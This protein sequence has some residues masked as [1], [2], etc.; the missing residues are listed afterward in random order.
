MTTAA[1]SA[2]L[3]AFPLASLAFGGCGEVSQFAGPS[4]V[5]CPPS[6]SARDAGA[7]TVAHDL[8]GGP[9]LFSPTAHGFGISVVLRAGD[10][11]MLQAR[12]RAAGTTDRCAWGDP[13]P[14]TVRAPDLAEWTIDGLA[15]ATTYEY[16]IDG[17]TPTGDGVLAAGHAV[18]Q[19]QPGQSFTFALVSDTHIGAD[20]TYD[21]QGDETILSAT[22]REIAA[23]RA[24][25]VV[26]LGDILDYH[27]YGFV[28]P[29]PTSAIARQAYVNYRTTL[30]TLVG[31]AFHF[32]VIGGWDAENG[33]DTADVIDRSRSQRLLYL[34]APGP[35]TNPEGGSPF[36]DYYAFTWGDALFVVLNVFT[37]TPTCHLLGG[38]TGVADDWTLGQTQLDWLR[39]TLANARSKWKFLLI[40]HPVGGN[41]GDD[42]DSAYGRG[43]GRAAH[44]G[45]Q[46]IVHE[47]MQ[48][49]GVQ[50]FFYGH[51]HVFTDML[52]DGI[53]YSLPGSAGAIWMFTAAETGYETFWPD[54]G[55]GRVDVTPENVHVVFKA[56]GAPAV[57][58]Y[59]IR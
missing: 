53:R 37:Y 46:E 57:F 15:P 8:Q 28:V 6:A 20:L 45:E 23:A 18:T 38:G 47:L 42:I 21:N 48:Q 59:T 12:V 17:C 58:D 29:P 52:V 3:L 11:E 27:Q 22:S 1:S 54:S 14:P 32:P 56:V 2:V 55:W 25:F 7:C 16:E 9:L 24:D 43:G 31:S 49:Y 30:G 10:P 26:N 13:V 5:A 34:P 51:D 41:A 4:A 33:C 35:T 40:H 19:R 36:Q 50:I 39:T 44:V